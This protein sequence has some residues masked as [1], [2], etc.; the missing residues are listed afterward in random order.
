MPPY[1]PER[2]DII[3]FNFDPRAGHEQAGHRPALVVS[4][5]AFNV[6]TG[7]ALVCPITNQMKGGSFEVPL[8]P[9]LGTTGAVLVEQVKS[10]DW[11]ERAAKFRRKAPAEVVDEVVSRLEA[12]IFP[13]V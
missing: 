6:A 7:L 13:D 9:G 4:S 1:Q 12:I 5:R 8:P 2:G 11:L 3:D 10:L